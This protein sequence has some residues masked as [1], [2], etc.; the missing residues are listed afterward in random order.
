MELLQ[1]VSQRGQFRFDNW[2]IEKSNPYTR[3]RRSCDRR[4]GRFSPPID[5]DPF[6]QNTGSRSDSFP[7]PL[8]M[9]EKPDDYDDQIVLECEEKDVGSPFHRI[10]T[11]GYSIRL[12]I[13]FNR[14]TDT[15]YEVSRGG[16]S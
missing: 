5:P 14:D 2:I 3:G 1:R 10:D 16:G 9:K 13:G 7:H 11:G 8:G 12:I 15:L 6:L 4:L